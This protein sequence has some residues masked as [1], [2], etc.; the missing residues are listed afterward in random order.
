MFTEYDLHICRDRVG[1]ELERT[2]YVWATLKRSGVNISSGSDCPVEP[3]DPNKNIYCAVTRKDF[4]FYPEG[5]WTPDEKLT[6]HEAIECHTVEAAKAVGMEERM[7]KIKEGYLCDMTVFPVDLEKINPD[8]I[9]ET[10]PIMT[11]IGGGKRLCM[12]R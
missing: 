2:S 11:I 8:E 10:K 4:K 1:E 3:L 5:G 6:V 9:L 7:G 12:V